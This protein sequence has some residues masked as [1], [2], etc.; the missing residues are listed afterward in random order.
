[1]QPKLLKLVYNFNG[2]PLRNW[3]IRYQHLSS[4]SKTLTAKQWKQFNWSHETSEPLELTY[5]FIC[6][7]FHRKLSM[8]TN[9]IEK[10]TGLN[11][12]KNLRVLSLGRNYIKSFTGL[13]SNDFKEYDNSCSPL[14]YFI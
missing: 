5:I 3:I 2:H 13:V 1:M 4:A 7:Y 11:G 8:S 10:I 12:M 6:I 9:M 14:S